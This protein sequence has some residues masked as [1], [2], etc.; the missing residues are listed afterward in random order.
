M[1]EPSGAAVACWI[2]SGIIVN[3][4]DRFVS[5]ETSFMVLLLLSIVKLVV[6]HDGNR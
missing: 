4:K 6:A 3:E 2:F 1:G 5:I